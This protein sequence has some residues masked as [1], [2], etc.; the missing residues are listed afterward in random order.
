MDDTRVERILRVAE[1]VP[2]G[3]IATYGDVGAVAG[4]SPRLVG[5]T[6]ALWGSSVPW[7]RICNARGEIPGHLEQAR[8]HWQDE[9]T[10]LRADGRVALNAARIGADAL[11]RLSAPRLAELGEGQ[12]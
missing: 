6:L 12:A 9:D 5:R 7:W 8:P 4:E 10:P 3:Q 11:A 2:A 1:C